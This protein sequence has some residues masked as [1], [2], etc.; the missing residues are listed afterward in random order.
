MRQRQL[1]LKAEKLKTA[2][3]LQPSSPASPS[4]WTGIFFDDFNFNRNQSK[5]KV[6]SVVGLLTTLV[7]SDGHLDDRIKFFETTNPPILTTWFVDLQRPQVISKLSQKTLLLLM[8]EA[9]LWDDRVSTKVITRYLANWER[10]DMWRNAS[11][12]ETAW[13]RVDLPPPLR[14]AFLKWY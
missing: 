12:L 7:G 14:A 3:I 13:I 9:F 11:K 5:E 6:R 1:L 2:R 10:C 4:P 8:C